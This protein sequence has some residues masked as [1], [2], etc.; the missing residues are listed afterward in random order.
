MDVELRDQSVG[1]VKRG[2]AAMCKGGLLYT[3][4]VVK[5][6]GRGCYVNVPNCM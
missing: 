5:E 1:V 6:R 3:V 2:G 4:G